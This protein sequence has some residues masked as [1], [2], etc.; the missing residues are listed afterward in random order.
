MIVA[1]P[2]AED[3]IAFAA[4]SAIVHYLL[5]RLGVTLAKSPEHLLVILSRN[6]SSVHLPV[7]VDVGYWVPCSV[8]QATLMALR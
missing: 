6:S 7:V 8:G 1:E 4:T 5:G 3:P 2:V